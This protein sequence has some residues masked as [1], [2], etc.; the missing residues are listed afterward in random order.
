VTAR[1]SDKQNGE[2]T[3][4]DLYNKY[5]S[6]PEPTVADY[7]A[8]SDDANTETNSAA[9]RYS[10][11]PEMENN[12]VSNTESLK[13][14]AGRLYDAMFFYGLDAPGLGPQLGELGS[15]PDFKKE[16]LRT[17][18]QSKPSPFLT[19]SEQRAL[20]LLEV[21]KK[22]SA[23]HKKE[24]ISSASNVSKEAY[25][26]EDKESVRKYIERLQTYIAKLER[27]L[28][29]AQVN[30]AADEGEQRAM[31]TAEVDNLSGR[32]DN[33]KVELVTMEVADDSR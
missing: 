13:S 18:G 7:E 25:N 30:L 19:P 11:D 15:D 28:S 10:E 24:G 29:L 2:P 16:A 22:R 12:E 31:L 6:Y 8:E 3:E 9:Y 20:H 17:Q 26:P 1:S 14:L 21:A 23:Q 32:L 5:V 27:E 4:V 33:A